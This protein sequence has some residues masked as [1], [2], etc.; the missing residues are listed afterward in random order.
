MEKLEDSSRTSEFFRHMPM[1]ERLTCEN[2]DLTKEYGGGYSF[3]P[4]ILVNSATEA[5]L[6]RVEE[7][8]GLYRMFWSHP[9]IGY[10]MC[11]NEFTVKVHRD[12]L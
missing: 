8:K 12:S 10:A 3:P 4:Y 5:R 7:G 9:N 6:L 1:A 11:M 2:L